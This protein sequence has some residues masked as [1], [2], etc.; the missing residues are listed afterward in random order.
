M[1]ADVLLTRLQALDGVSVRHGEPLSA[2]TPLRVGGPATLWAV[3]H[4]VAALRATLTAARGEKVRWRVLW[5]MEDLI[6]RDAGFN[7]LIIRPGR[8]FEGIG[9]LEAGVH[10]GAASPWAA[11]SGLVKLP[12]TQWSGTVGGLFAQGEQ[13]RLSGL[14]LTV[15][16]LKG[17]RLLEIRVEPGSPIPPLKPSEVPIGLLLDPTM[18]RRKRLHPPP[19]PGQLFSAP[20][21]LSPGDQLVRTGLVGTRL[22]DW[23]LSTAEPGCVVQI[24][25]GTCKDV[26]LLARGVAERVQR[27]RG[28]ELSLRIPVIGARS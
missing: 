28:V 7:G 14:G 18:P 5:P 25:Q 6:F 19:R 8:G 11:L 3:V 20:R 27:A 15:K 26:E 13:A 10:I 1:P 2:H 17:R 12:I 4:D 24:G 22:R 9:L 16:Y 21:G 23:R